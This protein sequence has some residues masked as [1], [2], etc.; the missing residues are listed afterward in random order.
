MRRDSDNLT[1]N[2]GFVGS[3]L[4]TTY[5]NEFC[6]TPVNV[7]TSD[8]SAGGDVLNQVN[9]AAT[10]G[11]T[12]NGVDDAYKIE[13]TS[14]GSPILHQVLK[15]SQ[16]ENADFT[17][18]FDYY[19]P[20]TNT[21]V[22]QIQVGFVGGTGTTFVG[23]LNSWNS[24]N[25]NFSTTTSGN[26]FFRPAIG[27][28]IIFD[29]PGE[30][31]YL[32]NM[33]VTQT[34][35]ANGYVTKWYDQSGN[36]NDAIQ[37]IASSQAKIFDSVIGVITEFGKPAIQFNGTTQWLDTGYTTSQFSQMFCVNNIISDTVVSFSSAVQLLF[38]RYNTIDDD[39]VFSANDGL[40]TVDNINVKGYRNSIDETGSA[41][42]FTQTFNRLYIGSLN[43]TSGFAQG[44][45]TELIIYPFAN[46]QSSNRT[47]IETN[48]NDF[49]SIY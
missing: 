27:T 22:N 8:F 30:L 11:E 17:I 33:V 24:V 35:A 40:F 13:T 32:K 20:S 39:V 1:A 5:L 18:S 7:Y 45:I 4:N 48:I 37:T 9:V 44:T 38:D 31:F 46:D 10:N 12:I 15:D 2:I 25:L 43:G 49:Y 19:I 36:S 23:G 3:E 42:V 29:A 6:N 34:S 47:G 28:N 14:T 26:L 16:N 21:V 41:T